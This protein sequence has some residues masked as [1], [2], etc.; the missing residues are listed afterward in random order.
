VAEQLGC[1]F[2]DRAI[3]VQVAE[4]LA[5]PVEH[6]EQHDEAAASR[7]AWLLARLPNTSGVLV[8]EPTTDVFC[9][10]TESLVVE[11]ADSGDVVVLGRA[12]ALV[13]RHRPRTLHVRLDGPAEA[14]VTQAMRIEEIDEQEARRRLR[15]SDRARVDY[16]KHFYSADPR[17]PRHYDVVLNSTT[18]PLDT[19]VELILT[20]ARAL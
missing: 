12:G 7:F 3:P 15:H 10:E 17:D 9:R 20:A 19:C 8:P 2:V 6:A 13:L 14:R 11:A 1:R 5:V 18:V 4:R 16:V